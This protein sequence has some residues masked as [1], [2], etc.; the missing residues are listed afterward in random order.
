MNTCSPLKDAI[1][2][3]TKT[4]HALRAVGRP[5]S[6]VDSTIDFQS[7]SVPDGSQTSSL[8]LRPCV[9]KLLHSR[10]DP[11]LQ[12]Q[13]VQLRYGLSRARSATWRD[14]R[15]RK[16]KTE[17]VAVARDDPFSLEDASIRR[18]CFSSY[19]GTEVKESLAKIALD[20]GTST[21][22][23]AEDFAQLSPTWTA[24]F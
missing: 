3:H 22:V 4:R 21:Q 19:R 12:K 10:I 5:I 18:T 11:M 7:K 6:L 14:F 16:T 15:A 13:D 24:G 2:S 9:V 17:R 8:P 1:E 23:L 20:T